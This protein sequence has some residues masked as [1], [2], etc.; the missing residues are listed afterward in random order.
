MSIA[1]PNSEQESNADS[2]A[3]PDD[4]QYRAYMRRKIVRGLKAIEEGR[5]LTH[6]E[7]ERRWAR[8]LTD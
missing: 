8:W 6:D 3:I 4:P 2:Y 7:V 5:V 1:K